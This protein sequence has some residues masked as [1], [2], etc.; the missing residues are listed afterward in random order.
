MTPVH[1]TV[2]M[3]VIKTCFVAAI[4]FMH[5]KMSLT[6]VLVSFKQ[7][8]SYSNDERSPEPVDLLRFSPLR[9][10]RY[11]IPFTPPGY[12]SMSTRKSLKPFGLLP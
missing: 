3:Q 4:L 12:S 9:T 6:M 10:N 5:P 8:Q 2:P 11:S 1:V 7:V